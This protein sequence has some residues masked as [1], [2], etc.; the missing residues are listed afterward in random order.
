MISAIP[1]RKP[2]FGT[3]SPFG[4]TAPDSDPPDSDGT[5][6]DAAAPDDSSPAASPSPARL[7]PDLVFEILSNSRRRLL[8]ERLGENAGESTLSDLAGHVAAV[9]NETPEAEL[10]SKERKRVYISLYQNHIPRMVDVDVVATDDD[11]SVTLDSNAADVLEFLELPESSEGSSPAWANYYAANTGLSA[12]V[13]LTGFLVLES[14]VP[15]LFA[16]SLCGYAA[17][18]GAHLQDGAD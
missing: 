13:L 11:G 7:P 17:L 4:G 3:P 12:T 15:L 1:G 6:P 2:D 8:L 10:T 9:E 16:L 5:D 14:V 18:V